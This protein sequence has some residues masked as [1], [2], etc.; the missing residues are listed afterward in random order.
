MD[1]RFLA[2]APHTLPCAAAGWFGNRVFKVFLES[3]MNGKMHPIAKVTE[4]SGYAADSSNS[5][6][7]S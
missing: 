3:S 1:I 4:L 7:Q 5:F 6:H 2:R